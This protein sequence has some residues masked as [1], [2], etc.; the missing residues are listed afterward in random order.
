MTEVA[1]DRRERVALVLSGGVSLGA[2]IAGALDELLHALRAASDRYV[3]DVITG[4]SA[5][6]TTGALIAHALTERNGVADLHKVWVRQVG[7]EALLAPGA[8]DDDEPLALLSHRVLRRYADEA[9]A[10]APAPQRHPCC[11]PE[12]LLAVTLANVD[13]LPYVSRIPI[14]TADGVEDLVQYRLSEQQLFRFPTS[15][16]MTPAERATLREACL[17]SSAIPFAFPQVRLRREIFNKDHYPQTPALTQEVAHYWYYDG[18]TYNNLPLDLAW[19]YIRASGLGEDGRHIIVVDPSREE[20]PRGPAER[21]AP[22]PL[23]GFADAIVRGHRTE[24]S[25][26]QFDRELLIPA[27]DGTGPSAL[28]GIDRP[29]VEL[30]RKIALVMPRREDSARPLR[31]SHLVMALSAFLDERFREYDFRRGAADARRV[32]R[33]RLQI[34]DYD[35]QRPGGEAFYHPDDDPA[36]AFDL[37][38]YESLEAIPTREDPDVSVREAFERLL[39]RRIQS[40]VNRVDP[41]GPDA[42][43]GFFLNRFVRGELPKLW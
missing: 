38:S 41:P 21:A 12:L 6:A 36:L 8:P 31:G 27:P 14:P 2:Y 35:A 22:P 37:A 13:A 5:G 32:A 10:P 1:N 28:P 26:L 23:F 7:A 17:A 3:I 25:A 18:G 34:T 29:R 11:A 4:A 40:I 9:L 19:Y 20:A 42:I 39:A 30:L 24:S 33:A 16:A 15:A 43:Y